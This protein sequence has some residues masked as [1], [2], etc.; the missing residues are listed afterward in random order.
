VKVL[1]VGATG[2]IGA[3]LVRAFIGAG[4]EVSCASR[5]IHSVP[6]GCAHPVAL[7][8]TE[9]PGFDELKRA[10]AGHDVVINAV[11]ILRERG[12]QT[13]S[14]LHDKGP[15]EL[16]AS[17][18]AA[19]VPRVIQISALGAA[20]DAISSYHRSKHAADEFLRQQPLDWAV[21]Q[22]SLVYGA[23][24][25]SARLFDTLAALP[26]TPLPAGGHQRVQ[27]VHIDDLVAVILELA[28]APAALKLT[29]AVA[30]PE[31][32]SL[33]EFLAEL[34][35]AHGRAP[36][37]AWSVPAGLVR[38]G[39]RF[40]DHLPGS[41]LDSETYG[42]LERGNVANVAAF[43]QWLRRAPRP[44]SRFLRPGEREARW[45]SASMQW[46]LPALRFSIA[47][48]WLIAAIV[49][50]GLYPVDASL[51]LLRDIGVAPTMAPVLLVSAIA[52][53]LVFGVLSLLPRRSKWLWTAQIAV[54]IGYTLIITWRLPELWLE[55]FG[56][57]AKNVPI[58]AILLLLHQLE[59][60]R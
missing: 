51:R 50:M 37:P 49:S 6:E 58:L 7:D 54:V 36:A 4:H 53:D 12:R 11:G 34:R 46:L 21:V 5:S 13:F 17:C 57:V 45:I 31:P 56:P 59:K 44:V 25:S 47:F 52:I 43:T 14:A 33:R 55:P 39:A 23:G 8:Y 24:G 22:P 48:M 1:I 60:R 42:M 16:F 38:L 9:L 2:F 41:M 3:R 19:G 20:A 29:L 26:M 27:P 32:L 35:A 30:G 15:R 28:V 18:A 10:V 40:G